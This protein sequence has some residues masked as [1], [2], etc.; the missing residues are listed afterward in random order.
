MFGIFLD[1]DIYRWVERVR[2]VIENG[3][4]RYSRQS[5]GLDEVEV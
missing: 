5:V 3:D 1:A 2:E 4:G